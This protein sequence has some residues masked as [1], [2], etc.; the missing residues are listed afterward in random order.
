MKPCTVLALLLCGVLALVGSPASA[1]IL[2]D[3]N[4]VQLQ[5]TA[6]IFFRNAATCK[7]LEESLP[8]EQYEKIKANHGQPI[9]LWQLDYSAHNNTG[10]PLDFLTA[11]FDI[12]SPQP[13]CTTWSRHGTEWPHPFSWGH[14]PFRNLYKPFGLPVGQVARDTLFL[15][16]F[17]QHKPVFTKWEVDFTVARQ[18]SHGKQ[19][20]AP[21]QKREAQREV[22]RGSVSAADRGGVGVCGPGGDD[23]R[24]LR[25]GCDRAVGQ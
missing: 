20:P 7:V 6:R 3:R 16:V 15:L 4:G 18:R 24:H 1:E 19:A 10:K 13:P 5:G 21:T 23:D 11:A 8:P 2:H 9:H 12:D 14:K 17:H 25:G 22:G